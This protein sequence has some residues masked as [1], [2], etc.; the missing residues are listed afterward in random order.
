MFQYGVASLAICLLPVALSVRKHCV[1]TQ[2]C[3][4]Q[5]RVSIKTFIKAS[6]EAVFTLNIV[7]TIIVLL[8]ILLINTCNLFFIFH[9]FS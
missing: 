9:Y 7:C 8:K 3:L 4:N 5:A 2:N 6:V 1:V